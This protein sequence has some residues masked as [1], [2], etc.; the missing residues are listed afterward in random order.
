M[1]IKT[2]LIIASKHAIF[3]FEMT[4]KS[5]QNNTPPRFVLSRKNNPL[6]SLVSNM[7]PSLFQG[8]NLSV[9]FCE[10]SAWFNSM[11]DRFETIRRG[12]RIVVKSNVMSSEHPSK[13]NISTRSKKIIP[14]SSFSLRRYG[15][16]DQVQLYIYLYAFVISDLLCI[17]SPTKNPDTLFFGQL[18]KAT[19][20]QAEPG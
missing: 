8:G 1:S 17:S 18:Q 16:L 15:E 20:D 5:G 14:S 12:T 2:R 3:R 6:L 7:I 19:S 10:L 11:G 13:N 4:S 9:F